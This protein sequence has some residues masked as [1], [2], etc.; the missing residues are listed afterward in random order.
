[1]MWDW[2]SSGWW[3]VA[4]WGGMVVFWTLAIWLVVV[5]VG[6]TRGDR[7][8]AEQILAERFS[9]GDI[10]ADQYREQLDVLHHG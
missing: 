7:A 1:M 3:L 5:L 2:H 4:M 6:R 9:R 10:D 8:S